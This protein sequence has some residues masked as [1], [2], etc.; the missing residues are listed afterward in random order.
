MSRLGWYLAFCSSVVYSARN[1]IS[2]ASFEARARRRVP[3]LGDQALCS[4]SLSASVGVA[5]CLST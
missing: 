2:L 4:L 3:V 1:V 5:S